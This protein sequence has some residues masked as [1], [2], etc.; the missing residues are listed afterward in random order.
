MCLAPS[1]YSLP[2]AATYDTGKAK[3]WAMVSQFIR[4]YCTQ[5]DI[6]FHIDGN[7]V[8]KTVYQNETKASVYKQN[9]S[10]LVLSAAQKKEDSL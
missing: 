2:L 9:V 8:N 5:A 6:T 3:F 10:G 4:T 1:L 7:T